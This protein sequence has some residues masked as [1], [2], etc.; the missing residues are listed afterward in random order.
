MKQDR[1]SAQFWIGQIAAY[2]REFK[3]WESKVEKIIQKYRSEVRPTTTKT[4][5]FNILW[6]NVQTI[7][8]AVFARV[9]K[10]S[11][12][13]R[14]RDNDPIGRVASL[15]IER[16]LEF[17]IDHYQD[18]RSAMKNS[19]LDRFLGGRGVAWVRYEPHTKPIEGLVDNPEDGPQVTE[20]VENEA[21]EEIPEEIDYECAPVDYVHWKDFGHT[22][23]RTWEEVGGVWRRV[24]MGREALIE[25][26]GEEVGNRIPLDTRPEK[27]KSS[28]G[29]SS[30][31][32]YQAAIYEI[33]DK[34]TNKALWVSKSWPETLDIQDDPLKLESFWPCP[35]PLYSTLGN[36]SLVPVP[37]YL[38][39][40]DQA[41][42]LDAISEKI[43][44]LIQALQLKGVHDASIPELSRLFSEAG[45][46]DLIPVGNWAAFA[47][48]S[49]L[50]GAIDLVDL[51]PIVTALQAAYEALAE[52]KNEIYEIIGIADI[53]RGASDPGETATAQRLKGQFGSLRLRA[54]QSDVAQYA[55]E[56]LQIKAQIMCTLYQ[57]ETLLKTA[58]VEEM[59]PE[60]QMLIPQALELL[61]NRPMRNFRIEISA[62]S[63]VQ[64]DET[65]EKADRMEFLQAAGG[66]LQNLVQLS[67]SP[68]APQLMPVAVSLMKFGVT[69]FKVGKGLEGEFDKAVD[70]IK[71]MVEQKAAQPPAPPPQIQLEQVKQQGE[72]QRIQAQGQMDAQKFQ[73]EQQAE[74]AKEQQRLWFE[75][76]KLALEQAARDKEAEN[77]MR[78]QQW[79]QAMQAQQVAHQNQLEAQRAELDAKNDRMMEMMRQEREDLR[80]QMREQFELL[81]TRLNNANKIDVAEVSKSTT[82]EAAQIA[83]A[84]RGSQDDSTTVNDDGSN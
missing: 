59:S 17:E 21:R 65:Q 67:Q 36:D 11:V 8:P 56:I 50:K 71:T 2:E 27:E 35:R 74:A 64:L 18:Y 22:H 4:A 84:N 53:V 31:D 72:M 3:E 30:D 28:V 77:D 12:T 43:D 26:F 47:E 20:D 41:L 76:Q 40:Q 6:S 5:Q 15:I 19:V 58:A 37:D 39:Y 69:A 60:D 24:F 52:I 16:G 81:I 51:Q 1:T 23:A 45:N 34:V 78:V 9:P 25:R 44:K 70:N 55:A 68:A 42:A 61:R 38:L 14:F 80:E 32:L 63:L 62:D 54:M 46:T 83:A 48:K 75:Q 82:L 66:F 7:M 79:T 49:G 29:G 57:P 73:A 10:P 13:R 33:W